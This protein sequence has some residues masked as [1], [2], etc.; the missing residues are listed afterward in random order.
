MDG[1]PRQPFPPF[2]GFDVRSVRES[3]D[4]VG[5]VGVE[6]CPGPDPA[7]GCEVRL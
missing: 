5:S 7:V 4:E 3:V 2:R 1:L 6:P